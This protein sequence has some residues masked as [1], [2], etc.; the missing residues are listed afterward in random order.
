ML[1]ETHPRARP[2]FGSARRG[3]G[4][5]GFGHQITFHDFVCPLIAFGF[6]TPRERGGEGQD[7]PLSLII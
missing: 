6:E 4:S 5:R 1:S 3:S 7:L 2:A